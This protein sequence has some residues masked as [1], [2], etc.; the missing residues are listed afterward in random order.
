MADIPPE[1]RQEWRKNPGLTVQLVLRVEGDLAE[2]ARALEDKG[3]DVKRQL[4]LT[5]S[6]SVSCSGRQA[7]GLAKIPWVTRIASDRPVRALGR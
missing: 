3:I 6:L 1:L 4:R 2:R 5:H 7:Q